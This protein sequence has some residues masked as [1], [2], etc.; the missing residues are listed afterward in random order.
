MKDLLVVQ[1]CPVYRRCHA[2]VAAL[3]VRCPYGHGMPSRL[4]RLRKI[5]AANRLLRGTA[6]DD[7]HAHSLEHSANDETL[8]ELR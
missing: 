4:C 2:V 7:A 6:L 1:R 5:K 8:D 3:I